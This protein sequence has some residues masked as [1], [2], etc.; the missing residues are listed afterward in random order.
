MYSVIR[1]DPHIDRQ[2]FGAEKLWMFRVF[3]RA[4]ARD[5]GGRAIQREG[6]FAGHHVHFIAAGQRDED[7]RIG[8]AGRFEHRRKRG[9]ADDG[10]DVEAVLQIAQDLLVG[11]DDGDLVGFFASELVGR[12]AP[13]LS[14]A[15]DHDFHG[16]AKGTAE[17]GLRIGA[18]P[19]KRFPS[20][21]PR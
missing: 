20:M 8:N 4:D 3:A 5:L 11:I 21:L 14:G 13:D 7:V 18:A 15:E 6:H 16:G 2:R 17:P 9:V 10:A 1:A 19:G 12:S